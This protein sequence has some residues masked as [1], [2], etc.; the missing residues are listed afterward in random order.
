MAQF[1]YGSPAGRINKLKGEIL[2][3][4]IPEEVLGIT[5]MQKK[6]PKN[7]GDN[8]IYRRY[9]P[10]GGAIT[11]ANTINRWSTTAAAHVV[12]EGVTPTADSLVPQDI[13][14]TMQQYGCLYQYTDKTADLYEDDVPMEMKKQTGER[15]GLVRELVR[16]GALK[17]GTNSYYSG[18]TTRLTVDEKITLNVLRKVARNLLA[19]HAKQIKQVLAPSPNF[20]TA[21][22]EAAFLVFV[23]SDAEADIRDLPGFK[24]VSEYGQRKP[25][26]PMEVGSVERF[27]FV[28]SP[29]LAAYADAGD[30]AAGT[31]LLSSGTKVD[32]YPFIVAAEDAWVQVALRGKDS[33]DVTHIP[34]GQKDKNDPH[35]QRGF[36]G[37]IGWFTCGI[38]NQGW[39]AVVEAG[40]SDL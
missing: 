40:V 29:E 28:V 19:N 3:H 30:T 34:V 11:N 1:T 33:F 9:L 27:R 38:T 14:V 26:H 17:A 6:M 36:I 32:V 23:H 35:G 12:A 24:H 2:K 31:G 13:T 37:A 18:G 5:G 20:N 16:F 25:V 7:S 21:P 10:F 4:A 39:M 8:I 15:M 22:V